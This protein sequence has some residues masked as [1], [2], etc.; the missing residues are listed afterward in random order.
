VSGSLSGGI[1]M[2][3]STV[4]LVLS[5]INAL[6]SVTILKDSESGEFKIF[7]TPPQFPPPRCPGAV[8]KWGLD[9]PYKSYPFAIHAPGSRFKPPYTL[10][11]V[12]PHDL[13]IRVRSSHCIGIP[14]GDSIGCASCRD[15]GNLVERVEAHAR[16]PTIQMDRT[17]L[18]FRQLEEKLDIMKKKLKKETLAVRGYL[19][20]YFIR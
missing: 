20:L 6:G 16:K 14:D 12:D 3:N 10:V 1:Y 13:S 11:S 9:S 5:Q 2:S 15:M 4:D 19:F 18:S 17:S 7:S 8:Y